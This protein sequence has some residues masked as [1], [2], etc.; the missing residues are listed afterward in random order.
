MGRVGKVGSDG[1]SSRA[2]DILSCTISCVRRG[3]KRPTIL[4]PILVRAL[5]RMHR[6]L[7]LRRETTRVAFA[8]NVSISAERHQHPF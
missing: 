3:R 6:G 5:L 7:R 8:E 2:L 1:E 4:G